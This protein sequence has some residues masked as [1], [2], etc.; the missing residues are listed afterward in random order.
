MK[1]D[2]Q[3]HL[4]TVPNVSYK[5]YRLHASVCLLFYE[6]KHIDAFGCECEPVPVVDDD[7]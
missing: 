3:I 5:Q 1:L 4:Q 7:G 2:F 6:L